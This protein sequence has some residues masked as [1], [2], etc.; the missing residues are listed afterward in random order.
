MNMSIKDHVLKGSEWS[1]T[2]Y[3]SKLPGA[4]EGYCRALVL[5]WLSDIH[6][7]H[8]ITVAENFKSLIKSHTGNLGTFAHSQATIDKIGTLNALQMT[9][10]H[11]LQITQGAL[12]INTGAVNT[13]WF[14]P[15]TAGTPGDAVRNALNQS[16]R[17]MCLVHLEWDGWLWAAGGNSAHAIGVVSEPGG[18]T[19]MTYTVFD[20]NYGIMRAYGVAGIDALMQAI[21]SE[22]SI[23]KLIALPL[24]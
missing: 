12:F 6:I 11:V 9:E 20:P 21:K 1:Q 23:C 7:N 16:I 17:S 10:V 8:K 5:Y 15:Q 4:G 3:I 13:Q 22:Y 24:S 19:G 14:R 2:D 18:S